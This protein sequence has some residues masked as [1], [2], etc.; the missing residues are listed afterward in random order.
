MIPFRDRRFR[1]ETPAGAPAAT[2]DTVDRASGPRRRPSSRCP[3][4]LQ[5]PRPA[6]PPSP[7]AVGEASSAR[8]DATTSRETAPGPGE[9]A[10]TVATSGTPVTKPGSGT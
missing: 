5:P 10:S 1:R 7:G 3:F 4:P 2:T 9:G 8:A 6:D